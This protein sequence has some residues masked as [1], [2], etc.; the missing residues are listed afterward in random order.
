MAIHE[1]DGS[2]S[3]SL[4]TALIFEFDNTDAYTANLAKVGTS[5]T[6]VE[7]DDYV[8]TVTHYSGSGNIDL[9]ASG[10]GSTVLSGLT[11]SG[12]ILGGDDGST[13]TNTLCSGQ[14]RNADAFDFTGN[15]YET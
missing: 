12:N 13:L 10:I 4:N 9:D 14:Y 15:I 7:N 1:N 8:A 11:G 2:G 5:N 6:R 3:M